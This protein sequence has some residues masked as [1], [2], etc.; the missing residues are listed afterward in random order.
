MNTLQK[1]LIRLVSTGRNSV[2]ELSINTGET[3]S[4][5]RREC[6]NLVSLGLMST[7]LVKSEFF[8]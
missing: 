6:L 8:S 7:N 2:T 5:I 3:Q 1:E 4:R